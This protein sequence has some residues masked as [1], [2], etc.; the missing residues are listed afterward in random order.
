MVY[1]YQQNRTFKCWQM[2]KSSENPLQRR[3]LLWCS[4][5]L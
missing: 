5:D 4:V 3:E 2:D 1:N